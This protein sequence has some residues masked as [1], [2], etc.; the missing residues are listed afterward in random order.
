MWELMLLIYTPQHSWNINI[1]WS[2]FSIFKQIL[3]EDVYQLRIF[4]QMG[5]DSFLSTWPA[6]WALS[7]GGVNI[8]DAISGVFFLLAFST[9]SKLADKACHNKKGRRENILFHLWFFLFSPLCPFSSCLNLSLYVIIFL[10][11]FY[12]SPC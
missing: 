3:L 8:A 10:V 9:C 12:V 4:N 11:L 7:V 2:K 1:K 6:C 5:W